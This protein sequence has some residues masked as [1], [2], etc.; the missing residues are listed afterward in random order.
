MSDPSL[1]CHPS[2]NCIGGTSARVTPGNLEGWVVIHVHG[3]VGNPACG[4][5]PVSWPSPQQLGLP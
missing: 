5:A 4:N 2:F 1:R 3:R